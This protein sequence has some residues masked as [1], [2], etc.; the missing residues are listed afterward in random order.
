MPIHWIENELNGIEW[1]CQSETPLPQP[2]IFNTWWRR[3]TGKSE[4]KSLVDNL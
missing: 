2:G 4:I 3:L 1:L